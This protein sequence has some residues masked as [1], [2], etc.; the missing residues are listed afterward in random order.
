MHELTGYI[1]LAAV[2]AL[3]LWLVV[4]GVRSFSKRRPRVTIR[5]IEP[6]ELQ[7]EHERGLLP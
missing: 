4:M 5:R 3:A 2:G 6:I 7:D 1:V